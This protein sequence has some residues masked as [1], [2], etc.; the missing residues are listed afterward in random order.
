V[1]LLL[2]DVAPDFTAETTH[3]R[4]RLHEFM[5]GSWCVLFSHPDDFT[6]VCTTELGS[7]RAL[8]AAAWRAACGWRGARCV[9]TPRLSLSARAKA[10][11]LPVRCVQYAV[12]LRRCSA[13]CCIATAAVA[14]ALLRHAHACF[15]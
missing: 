4:L 12:L 13:L 3:G 6:P 15:G 7:V 14:R 8:R 2:G 5:S 1:G 11:S 10:L 9:R